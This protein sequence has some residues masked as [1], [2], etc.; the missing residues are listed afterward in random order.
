MFAHRDAALVVFGHPQQRG[1]DEVVRRNADDRSMRQ[2][3][4]GAVE[5][6]AVA[7][8]SVQKIRPGD[9]ADAV[10]FADEQRV[11]FVLAHQRARSAIDS[12]ASINIG[13]M[14]EEFADPRCEHRR[15]ARL[16]LFARDR[17]ELVGDVEIEERGE[18]R[19]PVDESLSVTSR[20]RRLHNVSSRATKALELPP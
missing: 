7:E 17:V 4:D 19:V 12:V 18:T 10:G 15:E 16:L 14:K 6:A 1:R 11:G 2:R 8:R 9:D 5:R 13:G 3:T 20:G